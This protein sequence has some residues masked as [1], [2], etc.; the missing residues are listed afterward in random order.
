VPLNKVIWL[1]VKVRVDAFNPLSPIDS[2][3]SVNGT[4]LSVEDR[5]E[6]LL[7]LR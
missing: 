3:L 1:T 6:K 7:V 2:V 4:Q 5:W